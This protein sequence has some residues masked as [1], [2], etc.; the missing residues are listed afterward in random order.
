MAAVALVLSVALLQLAQFGGQATAY[1]TQLDAPT[2][3][4]TKT[5]MGSASSDWAFV[6][7]AQ[8]AWRL[9]INSSKA[10]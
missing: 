1:E 5:V 6:I 9:T 3:T 2:L 7:V 10:Q 8:T 4:I